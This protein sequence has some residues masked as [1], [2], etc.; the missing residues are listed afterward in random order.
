MSNITTIDKNLRFVTDTDYG[1]FQSLVE[2]QWVTTYEPFFHFSTDAHL[3]PDNKYVADRYSVLDLLD[4]IMY[5]NTPWVFKVPMT[6][7]VRSC[8]RECYGAAAP[9]YIDPIIRACV[10]AYPALADINYIEAIY[11]DGFYNG[12]TRHAP[13]YLMSSR[14]AKQFVYQLFGCYSARLLKIVE[15]YGGKIDFWEHISKAHLLYGLREQ[16]IYYIVTSKNYQELSIEYALLDNLLPMDNNYK[17]CLPDWVHN[18]PPRRRAQWVKTDFKV[19]LSM[20]SLIEKYDIPV[21]EVN[22]ATPDVFLARNRV[23]DAISYKN[24][25]SFFSPCTYSIDTVDVNMFT[26]VPVHNIHE[27]VAIGERLNICVTSPS[28]S[29]KLVTGS[30]VFF[31]GTGVSQEEILI[32]YDTLVNRIVEAR[33]CD[34]RKPSLSEKELELVVNQFLDNISYNSKITVKQ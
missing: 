33:S 27:L 5:V 26:F 3:D 10:A 25:Q 18:V 28:Y 23:F 14:N 4:Q 20:I 30:S 15:S 2:G 24:A 19:F 13:K 31:Y 11:D 17:I 1:E 29:Q 9:K 22:L 16:D 6:N 34:N 21:E 12:T 7:T 8:A 32:E